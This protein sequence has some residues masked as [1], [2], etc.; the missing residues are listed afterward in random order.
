MTKK[1]EEKKK[2]YTEEYSMDSSKLV[3]K[4]KGIIKEGNARKIIIKNQD[5]KEILI[6][7]L[8]WGA[9]GVILAPV[10]AAVGAIA[11][12]VTQ[13]KVVV[14]RENNEENNDKT[15]KKKK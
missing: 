9:I 14:V 13:S 15:A 7:P 2:T 12:V 3:E 6:I 1:S 10:L 5:D 11:A 4:V 8:T